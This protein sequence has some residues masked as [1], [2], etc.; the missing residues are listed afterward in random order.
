MRVKSVALVFFA[1]IFASFHLHLIGFSS[2]TLYI[3]TENLYF[4]VQN[5]QY[6]ITPTMLFRQLIHAENY[7]QF[8]DTG[9]YITAPNNI[10]I[11]LH[12]L[13]SS[14]LNA[15]E[16]DKLVNFTAYTPSGLV[17]FNLSGFKPN[18]NYTIQRDAVNYTDS[19]AN[20]SGF[21]SWNNSLWDAPKNF[22]V[23]VK[24]TV[25]E[26]LSAFVLYIIATLPKY[27]WMIMILLLFSTSFVFIMTKA[28]R[29][30]SY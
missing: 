3:H 1:I 29:R 16:T 12:F 6:N 25:E 11:T 2:A 10:N 17:W 28:K 24:E 7:M 8:N 27:N 18:S 30:R 23:L 22:I 4:H 14:M 5:E 20:A 21:I 9:F 15:N 19:Q 26:K 13:N